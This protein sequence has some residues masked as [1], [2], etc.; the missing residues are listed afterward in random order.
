MRPAPFEFAERLDRSLGDPN[1]PAGVFSYRRTLEL[2]Q[3]EEF[4][5]DI[6][7]LL[8][9]LGLA[10]YY[11]PAPHGG[12][13][14]DYTDLMMLGRMLSRRDFTVA[15]AHAK[16][17]LGAACAWTGSRR[18]QAERLAA[19]VLDGQVVC[20]ALTEEAH[21]ADL[22]K[23]EVSAQPR[24]RGFRL[25]GEKWLINNATRGQVVCLLARTDPAGGPRGFSLLLIDKRELATESWR[26]LPPVRTHGVRGADI[27]GIRF[28]D[29]EVARDALVGEAGTGLET[30]LK[31]MQL[32]R[33]LCAGLSLG[34]ADHAL[35]VTMDFATQ[36]RLYNRVLTDLPLAARTLATAYADLL[37][38]E[39]V[40]LVA[41]RSVHCLTAEMSVVS[42]IVKYL[43]PTIIDGTITNLSGVLGARA[44]LT[45][46][47]ADGRFQKV[48]RDHQIVG[49]FDGSTHV[50]PG[51]AHQPAALA[52]PGLPARRGR[53]G[54]SR[55]GCDAGRPSARVGTQSPHAAV[56]TGLQPRPGPARARG[57]GRTA[58]Q[59]RRGCGRR[60]LSGPRSC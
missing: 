10:R 35:R 36:H 14:V 2:D 42:A 51:R 37:L 5:R 33:T 21:G 13:L 20:L 48:Q 41:M 34:M 31:S 29:A 25:N 8:D 43:V 27:S 24:G 28:A 49:I 16:T 3:H 58:R 60:W 9:S 44:L 30:V 38:C 57:R 22:L 59:A 40:T 17:Y 6:C 39:A 15:L 18:E 12:D 32:T 52:G 11:V 55:C 4:P 54:R 45:Q 26:P 19:K 56:S 46:H 50:E 53:R 7:A 47:F 1:D 23:G